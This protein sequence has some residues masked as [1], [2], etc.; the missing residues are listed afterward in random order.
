MVEEAKERCGAISLF[1]PPIINFAIY[2]L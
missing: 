1:S 2:C